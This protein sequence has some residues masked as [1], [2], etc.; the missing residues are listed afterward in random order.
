MPDVFDRLEAFPALRLLSRWRE[1]AR[2]EQE[3]AGLELTIRGDNVLLG[4]VFLGTLVHLY[5]SMMPQEAQARIAYETFIER[6]LRYLERNAKVLAIEPSELEVTLFVPDG[7]KRPNVPVVWKNFVDEAFSADEMQKTLVLLLNSVKLAERGFSVPVVPVVSEGEADALASFVYATARDIRRRLKRYESSI[8]KGEKNAAQLQQKL[9][10]QRENY[11]EALAAMDALEQRE[12]ERMRRIRE[13]A[14]NYTTNATSQLKSTRAIVAKF[15][16]YI[17]TLLTIP[18]EEYIEIPPLL[19]DIPMVPEP[20][21]PGDAAGQLCYACGCVVPKA[22]H[23]GKVPVYKANKFI[24]QAPSQTLQGYFAQTEPA[25]CSVCAALAVAC[26]IKMADDALIVSMRERGTGGEVIAGHSGSTDARWLYD[27]HLQM[28]TTGELRVAAGRYLLIAAKEQGPS[29]KLLKAQMGGYEYALFKVASLL[30]ADVLERFEAESFLGAS[31]R[32]LPQR[33]VVALRYLIDVFDVQPWSLREDKAAYG[34]VADAVRY[35]ERDA[36]NHAIY[37]LFIGSK[38]KAHYSEVDLAWLE[39]GRRA[40]ARGLKYMAELNGDSTQD[41]RFRDVAGLTGVLYA[42]VSR[43]DYEMR[44]RGTK[45]DDRLRELKKLVEDVSNPNHFTY[46]AAAHLNGQSAQL[47]RTQQTWFVYD[48]AMGLLDEVGAS[49]AERDT[50][51]ANGYRQLQVHFDDIDAIYA[52]LFTKRYRNER[53]QR[54]FTY[55]LKLSL[56]SRFP[57]MVR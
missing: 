26:P 11:G 7:V 42:L 4:S 34:A 5:G 44:Q 38:R 16:P 20:R 57:E 8:A 12:P 28:L 43:C 22:R 6:F 27:Q 30:A 52:W 33:H 40:F 56:Y 23:G 29:G 21:L 3:R 51:G 1:R 47:R 55:E 41:R 9:D 46:G 15:A 45:D 25:V 14:Q 49:S 13:L 32:E 2:N 18:P 36:L 35:V 19:A 53:D 48:E 10:K 39:R 37:R 31:S 54:D 17:E 24:L 50:P